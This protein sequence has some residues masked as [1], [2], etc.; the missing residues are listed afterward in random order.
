VQR[1][2]V[3]KIKKLS[4]LVNRLYS[5][6]VPPF[7]ISLIQ[8]S[9]DEIQSIVRDINSK[10]QP[11]GW[12]RLDGTYYTVDLQTFKKIIAWDWTDTRKYV[13]DRFDCD[14]FA[15][16][17]KSRMAIDYGVNAVGVVLDYSAGH[18]Y[19]LVIVKNQKVDWFLY[20]PQTDAL[21]KFENRDKNFYTM[22]P[23]QWYLL[24]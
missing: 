2:L 15:I 17:F 18:A 7:K 3:E 6:Y 10:S 12:L 16:Y 11:A 1:N 20:E 8:L 5:W 24:L 23:R 13:W 19:N 9:E 21:F 4:Q 22:S 14:K